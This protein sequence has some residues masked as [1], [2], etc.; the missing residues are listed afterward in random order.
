MQH[1]VTLQMAALIIAEQYDDVISSFHFHL[2]ELQQLF[3]EGHQQRWNLFE[4]S[5]SLAAPLVPLGSEQQNTLEHKMNQLLHKFEEKTEQELV[6]FRKDC[7]ETRTQLAV[8]VAKAEAQAKTE[9]VEAQNEVF[10]TTALCRREVASTVALLKSEYATMKTTGQGV[11]S[12]QRALEITSN[13]LENT[14]KRNDVIQAEQLET[15]S[16]L[17][18]E[19]AE[20]RNKSRDTVAT[21]R[22]MPVKCLR[23]LTRNARRIV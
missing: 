8:V 13:E 17:R 4:L 21:E 7:E 18:S 22:E 9:R 3:H 2:L 1:E 14:R 16:K 10:A 20:E 6:A 19:L 23:R 15:I 11:D 12:L 5:C